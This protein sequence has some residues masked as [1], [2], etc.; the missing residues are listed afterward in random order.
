M[1]E[2]KEEN[3]FATILIEWYS[4]QKKVVKKSVTSDKGGDNVKKE[5]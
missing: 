2:E 4:K 5:S 1:A 3:N